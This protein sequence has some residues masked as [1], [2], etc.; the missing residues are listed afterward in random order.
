[1]VDASICVSPE[2]LHLA[3]LQHFVLVR[4]LSPELLLHSESQLLVVIE[5]LRV[6]STFHLEPL[7]EM[8]GN[9]LVNSTPFTKTLSTSIG[10]NC[11]SHSRSSSLSSSSFLSST[12]FPGGVGVIYFCLSL[13]SVLK[14]L[15]SWCK[16]SHIFWWCWFIA[17]DC[18]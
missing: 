12:S 14:I 17:E 16:E 18:D 9:E 11:S 7:P 8:P 1:M 4:L 15:V 3:S 2:W 5:D 13:I 6:D 10:L